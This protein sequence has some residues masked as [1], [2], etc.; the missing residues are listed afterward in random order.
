MYRLLN[1]RFLY[2][3]PLLLS[4]IFSLRA[5]R[6]KWPK[7]Y[8][9]YAW[10]LLLS[11]FTEV[12]ALAWKWELY[13]WGSFNYSQNNFWIYNFFLI[14]RFGLLAMI[15]NLTLYQHKL[16]PLIGGIIFLFGL[17]DYAFIHGPLQFNTFSMILTHICIITLCLLYFRQLLQEP[18][19]IAIQKEPLFWMVIGL[20]FYH[21]V[22]LPFLINLGFF[23]LQNYRLTVYFFPINEALNFLLCSC[24]LISFLWKPQYSQPL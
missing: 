13:H 21:A 23:N 18:G 1:H 14:L 3:I 5:F 17:L 19:I 4:A 24:Y 22:S 11:L 9:L 15:F 16:I 6:Q 8:R 10:M 12:A 2:L 7:P 20:F